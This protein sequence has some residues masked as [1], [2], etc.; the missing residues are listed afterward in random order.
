[1]SSLRQ[2]EAN[3]RNAQK[4]TGPTS[5][6]GKAVSS[7][8]ALKTGIHAKSLVLPS[9]KLADLEQL[10]D[11][12]YQRHN[13]TTPEARSL[14][15]DLIY[16]E[17]LKR[18]LRAAETQIWALRPPGK[19]PSRPQ[20]PPRSDRRQPRQSLRPTP[21]AHRVHPPRLPPGPARPPTTPGRARSHRPAA[22]PPVRNSHI[23]NH[24]TR[25]WLRSSHPSS[26]RPRRPGSRAGPGPPLPASPQANR[27]LGYS[28]CDEATT[29]CCGFGGGNHGCAHRRPLRQR[30]VPG[31]PAGYRA[32]QSA[33]AEC[34]GTGRNRERCEAAARRLLHRRRQSADHPRQFR[35]RSGPRRP[36]RVDHRSR[37]RESGDQA[38][39]LAPR[40]GAA[41]AG[42]D[43]L[44]QHQRHS[45][46]ADLP[47]ASTASSGSTFWARTSSIRRATC[48]WPR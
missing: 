38:R 36:M 48:T 31:G 11:D 33:Q 28:S 14:V 8:N 25:N 22:M 13:P 20:V 39:P 27:R 15:D 46:G 42:L 44:H 34:G 5:V 19:L 41:R 45:A 40:G 29:P 35:G 16:G 30:R 23:R 17:W 2:I 26:R 10:I 43:R 3:R 4:S 12:Y 18:R 32:A 21:V 9:E 24:F 1:M 47:R 37:G 6:T 7:M